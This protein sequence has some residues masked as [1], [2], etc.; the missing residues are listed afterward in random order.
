LIR[1]FALL[2]SHEAGGGATLV[3][4]GSHRLVFRMSERI[5]THTR[6]SA[7][8]IVT[9]TL[10]STDAWFDRLFRPG[11]EPERSQWLMTQSPVVDGIKVGVVEFTGQPGDVYL[12][13]P[14]ALHGGS[15]NCS[16]RP[17]MM[18]TMWLFR[19]DDSARS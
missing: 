7:S 4:S 3:V 18:V 16:D 5:K 17:R 14:W 19:A 8:A 2:G 12:M 6:L 11:L 10:A 13:H 9:R 15:P 1:I